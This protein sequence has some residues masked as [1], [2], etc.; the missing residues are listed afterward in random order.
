[1]DGE[2]PAEIAQAIVELLSDPAKAR[3]MGANGRDWIAGEWAWERVAARF[4]TLL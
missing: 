4:H 2:D 3:K 1:V